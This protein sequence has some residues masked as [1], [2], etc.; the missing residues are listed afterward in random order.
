MKYIN[1]FVASVLRVFNLPAINGF[2]KE[3]AL[4]PVRVVSGNQ[5]PLSTKLKG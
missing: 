2:S 4:V 5:H 3:Q 1:R